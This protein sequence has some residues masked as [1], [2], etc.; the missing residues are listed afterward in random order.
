M[1]Y[2][3]QDKGEEI[4]KREEAIADDR[5]VRA[6][7]DPEPAPFDPANIGLQIGP[8]G[9]LIANGFSGHVERVYKILEKDTVVSFDIPK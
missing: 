4:K 1:S 9:I 5:A 8:V 2:V 7:P 6:N 3:K